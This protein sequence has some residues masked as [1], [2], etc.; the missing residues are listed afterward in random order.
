MKIV[1]NTSYS[2][3]FIQSV[4]KWFKK[5]GIELP[6]DIKCIKAIKRVAV[7]KSIVIFTLLGKSYASLI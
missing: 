2:Q 3:P 5:H 1:I 6:K 4:I 7:P